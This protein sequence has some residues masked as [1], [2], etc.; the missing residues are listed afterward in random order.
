MTKIGNW[1]D[2]SKPGWP[3]NPDIH[4]AHCVIAHEDHPFPGHVYWLLWDCM[5]HNWA[6]AYG[7]LRKPEDMVQFDYGYS[8]SK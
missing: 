4:D 8:A 5:D 7:N 6:D 1:P 3:P 2:P